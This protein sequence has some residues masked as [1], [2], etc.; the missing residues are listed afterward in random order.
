MEGEVVLYDPERH[1]AHSLN[2]AALSV[3]NHCDGQST[4]ADL[5]RL[6]SHELGVSIDESTIRLALKELELA[7]LLAEKLEDDDQTKVNRRQVLRKAGRW[8]AAAVAAPLVVS[9][10]VPTAA[11]AVSF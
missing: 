2:R 3:W 6:V 1:L 8:G 9:A 10:L 4:V 11:A 5:Q 7:H